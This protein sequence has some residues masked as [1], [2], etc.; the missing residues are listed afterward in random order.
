M[1]DFAVYTCVMRTARSVHDFDDLR[2]ELHLNG[3][4]GILIWDHNILKKNQIWKVV[5][6]FLN[7]LEQYAPPG[8]DHPHME[9]QRDHQSFLSNGTGTR[10]QGL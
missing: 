2:D 5:N 8:N 4:E 3:L 9:C 6:Y 7:G 1:V 10:R